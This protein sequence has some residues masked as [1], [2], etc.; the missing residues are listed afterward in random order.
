MGS[1]IDYIEC[2]NCEHEAHSDFYYKTGEQIVNC[3][4]CGY[5][6]SITIKDR[7][8]KLNEITEDDF[9]IKT[10][11]DPYGSYRISFFDSKGFLC[12]TILNE[13]HFMQIK[14]Q[15]E[16]DEKI[17]TFEV[18]RYVDKK[19]KVEKIINNTNVSL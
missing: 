10:I 5:H 14:K 8:K 7:T 1:I 3:S 15:C 18:S 19:I 2:P 11:T 16:S 12:G 17:H 6:H 9:E 13:E 4:F